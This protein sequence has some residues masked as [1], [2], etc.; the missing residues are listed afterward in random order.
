[1]EHVK[2]SR[3]DAENHV[4]PEAKDF[5]SITGYGVEAFVSSKR[6]LV[7]NK[8]LMLDRD[9]GIRADA[10]EILAEIERLA[11]TGV[12]VC[13][14]RELEGILAISDPLKPGAS[15]VVAIL[16]SMNVNSIMVTGDNWGTA[17]AIAKDVGI[18]TVAAEAKP[19]HKADKV[20]ELQVGILR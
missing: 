17:T 14:D 19:E 4:W 16:K 8:N 2:K 6:V 1:M 9:V 5:K 13:I 15:E 3:R 11:Q 20:K 12:L 18:D 7:G 10:M